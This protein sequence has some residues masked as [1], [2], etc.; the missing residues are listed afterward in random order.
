MDYFEPFRKKREFYKNNPKEINE[1]L[2]YGSEKAKIVADGVID[3]VR[4]ATGLI[5]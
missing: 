5:I 4:S 1:I 2:K 3:R